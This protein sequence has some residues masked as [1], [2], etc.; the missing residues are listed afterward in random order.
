MFADISSLV[1]TTTYDLAEDYIELAS[2]T[3][4]VI[5]FTDETP[6]VFDVLELESYS[7]PLPVVSSLS[8][9]DFFVFSV[10]HL[11]M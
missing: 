6:G 3:L 8:V 1:I 4:F 10:F 11:V 2:N 9:V 5:V 7:T